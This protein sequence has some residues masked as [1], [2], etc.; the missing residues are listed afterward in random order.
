MQ[1]VLSDM[2]AIDVAIV[3]ITLLSGALGI[4]WGVLRQVL[5]IVGVFAGVVVAGRYGPLAADALMSFV[6]DAALAQA[7][8]FMLV[9]GAVSGIASLVA[10]LLHRYAGLLFLGRLDH[11]LG[12]LLGTAQGLLVCVVLLLALAAF[13]NADWS[14]ALGDSRF[15]AALG[16]GLGGPILRL[17]PESYRF[18][19]QTM[20]GL[21]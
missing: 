13:P 20:L 9:F 4:Y 5:S 3:V 11:L 6:S 17:L 1:N 12:G 14:P 10:S 7:I 18:A 21:P 15:A 16:G 2:N 8:G 19:A